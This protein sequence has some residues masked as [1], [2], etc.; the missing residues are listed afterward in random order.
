MP[1]SA[2]PLFAAMSY[3]DPK[4]GVLTTGGQTALAQ[5]HSAINSI[6]ISVSGEQATGAATKWTL[7]HTP[8]ASVALTGI[9]ANGPVPLAPGKG[10]PWSYTIDGAGITTEQAF[11]GVIASYE[12]AQS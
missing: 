4:T 6:P 12:Y 2:K 3:T 8:A 11:E 1:I 5:W 10:N 9:S 7:A